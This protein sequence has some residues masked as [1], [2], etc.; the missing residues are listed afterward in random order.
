MNLLINR[1]VSKYKSL[2]L[3]TYKYRQLFIKVQELKLKLKVLEKQNEELKTINEI[4]LNNLLNQVFYNQ[5]FFLKQH[6]F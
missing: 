5:F 2:R 4:S 3:F 1:F 6:I